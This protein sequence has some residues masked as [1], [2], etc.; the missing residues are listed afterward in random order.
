VE[1][2]RNKCNICPY[3]QGFAQGLETSNKLE[4]DILGVTSMILMDK[5]FKSRRDCC[6]KVEQS[7]Q[8]EIDELK[9][10]TQRLH[11]VAGVGLPHSTGG[12]GRMIVGATYQPPNFF[13]NNP[14]TVIV[15][16]AITRQLLD[17]IHYK[18]LLDSFIIH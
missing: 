12:G 11:R 16:S 2:E 14:N 18:L 1:S 4:C 6:K 7:C 8:L 17:T 3:K 10:G 15:A 5:D 9:L 13:E